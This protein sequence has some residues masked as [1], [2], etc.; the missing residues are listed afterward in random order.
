MQF[1]KA[2]IVCMAS[3]MALTCRMVLI[4]SGHGPIV[5]H[6]MPEEFLYSLRSQ[7][8]DR[9]ILIEEILPARPGGDHPL[10]PILLYLRQWFPK[11]ST[12]D[13]KRHGPILE[14]ILN[15]VF[16]A[17]VD[18]VGERAASFTIRRWDYWFIQL[19][20]CGRLHPL[21]LEL[22][23]P[24]SIRDMKPP[25]GMFYTIPDL[26]KALEDILST[27]ETDS[28]EIRNAPAFSGFTALN[29]IFPELFGHNVD[30][31]PASLAPIASIG[32]TGEWISL[33]RIMANEPLSHFLNRIIAE[34]Q[35]K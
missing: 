6:S 27:I 4:Q 21:N 11:I 24:V 15:A 25:S 19:S 33:K 16:C 14:V 30:A 20:V 10:Q 8:L 9:P 7:V 34:H 29:E 13:L 17:D 23:M 35:K 12:L 1:T 5:L 18:A 3:A 28:V 22:R 26:Y 32:A 31:N 2:L